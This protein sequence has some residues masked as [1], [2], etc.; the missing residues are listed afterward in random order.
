MPKY[1]FS[2]T[3][4]AETANALLALLV[5]DKVS[6]LT[7][8]SE[9]DDVMPHIARTSRKKH[10]QP[11]VTGPQALLGCVVQAG[12]KL[13]RDKA[14]RELEKIGYS[15]N[16]IGPFSSKLMREGKL[17]FEHPNLIAL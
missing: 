10:R 8:R 9:D 6:E 5:Q 7:F 12:G 15:H 4:T 11:G 1:Y 3:A 17:K 14:Q 13:N 2:F 16:S